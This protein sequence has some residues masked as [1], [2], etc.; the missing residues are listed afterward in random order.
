[1]RRVPTVSLTGT[2]AE[3]LAVV[4][5][6]VVALGP[7]AGGAGLAGHEIEF[8]VRSKDA[9]QA[10]V[11]Y[12]ETTKKKGPARHF[13]RVTNTLVDLPYTK[14]VGATAR[15]K[16]WTIAAWATDD[17]A[18]TDSPK[19]T[20]RCSIEVDGKRTAKSSATDAIAFCHV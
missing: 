9:R 18:A 20:V 1:M 10:C 13:D 4:V 15:A 12:Y 3:L 8:T 5:A 6:A 19:G 17:C 2:L 16:H 7:S 14:T 11:S